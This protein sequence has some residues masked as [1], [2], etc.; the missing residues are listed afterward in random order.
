MGHTRLEWTGFLSGQRRGDR[1]VPVA[2]SRQIQVQAIPANARSQY[3]L[4]VMLVATGTPASHSQFRNV[5]KT[6]E[7]EQRNHRWVSLV[8]PHCALGGT[9][10]SSPRRLARTLR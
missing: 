5:P 9:R 2:A 10:A 1:G 3:H 8:F 4:W 7:T 6:G